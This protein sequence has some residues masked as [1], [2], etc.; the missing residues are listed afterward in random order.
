[1]VNLD[2]V[3]AVSGTAGIAFG[4]HHV[5]PNVFKYDPKATSTRDKVKELRKEAEDCYATAQARTA[6]GVR[7]R[8]AGLSRC[9]RGA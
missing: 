1:M 2:A 4:E 3:K 8:G 7:V 6:W 5:R 9:H